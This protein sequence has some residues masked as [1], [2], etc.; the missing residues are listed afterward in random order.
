MYS[1]HVMG[2]PYMANKTKQRSRKVKQQ[3]RQPKQKKT[4]FGDVGAIV[5]S[6]VGNLLGYGNA[7]GIGRWLGTGIGSIFGS[8][9]YQMVGQPPEYNVLTNGKQIPKFESNDRTNI[10]CHRE[11]VGDITSST[12]FKNHTFALNPSDIRT[13]P[14]LSNVARNYQQYR[15]HGMIFEF[16]PLITDYIPSGQPGVV[17]FATNY[18]A[19]EPPFVSKVEME[20]SEFAVS[21]KPTVPLMHAIECN[22]QENSLTRLYVDRQ[23]NTDKRFTDFGLTQFGTQGYSSDGVLL[24]EIWVSYCIEFFKPKLLNEP[25]GALTAFVK[26]TSFSDANPFGTIGLSIIG[27]LPVAVTPTQISFPAAKGTVWLV[28]VNWQGS[29]SGQI[30]AFYYTGSGYNGPNN[31]QWNNGSS[32]YLSDTVPGVFNATCNFVF[33]ANTTLAAP[34]VLLIPNLTGGPTGTKNV[35]ILITQLDRTIDD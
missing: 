7:K 24:G 6:A 4:P 22:P 20:N 33:V 31:F 28:S 23:Q 35:S 18:N 29:S 26:R 11:F 14:W 2:I 12:A 30:T 3:Q 8:G 32:M 34:D 15:I 17:V 21:V 13:F 10:I 25:G 1:P 19:A 9:D 27:D 16:R 5:G